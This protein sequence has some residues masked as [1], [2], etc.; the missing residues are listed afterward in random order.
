MRSV[1]VFS[2]AVMAGTPAVEAKECQSRISGVE[3]TLGTML[4]GVP[5]A[6]VFLIV[7][8]PAE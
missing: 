7:G 8:E 3:F 1:A 4:T 2:L 6:I 5:A